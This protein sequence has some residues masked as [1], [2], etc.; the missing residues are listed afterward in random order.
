MKK[1]LMFIPLVF[2][3]CFIVGC[4]QGER[5]LVEPMPD[6]EADIQAIKDIIAEF[7]DALNAADIDGFMSFYAH[8]AAVIR[9]NEPAAIGKEAVRSRH[10]KMFDEFNRWENRQEDFLVK[11][12]QVSGN[13]AIARFLWSFNGKPKDTEELVKSNG[14]EIWV[15]KK[16]PNDIWKIIYQIW[17]NESLIYPP[18]PEQ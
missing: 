9:P 2:L 7:N 13:L 17:S 18:L 11:D 6:V 16:Q 4:Q 8:D 1:L 14:N 15:L 5:V 12:I 10:Q 3:C